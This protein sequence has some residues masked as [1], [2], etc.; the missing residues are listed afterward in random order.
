MTEP[1]GIMLSN[2]AAAAKLAAAF[3]LAQFAVSC[4]AARLNCTGMANWAVD[5]HGD[6]Q[7]RCL[8]RGEFDR[9]VHRL[10]AGFVDADMWN[11]QW[12]NGG[13][14]NTANQPKPLPIIALALSLT[15]SA[16]CIYAIAISDSAA[17]VSGQH[18]H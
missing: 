9:L 14:V 10:R 17:K 12:M 3:W 11:A 8:A 6:R 18:I 1:T 7:Y 16:L 5:P 15:G 13:P 4:S 2:A